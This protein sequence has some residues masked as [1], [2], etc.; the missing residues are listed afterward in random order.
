MR[1]DWAERFWAKVRKD[2]PVLRPELGPCWVWTAAKD[3]GYGVFRV[4]G[5]AGRT[6]R[7]THCAWEL[8]EGRVVARGMQICH[9]CDNPSCVRPSHLFE[10]TVLDNARDRESKGR[11]NQ[12]RG[13]DHGHATMTEALV[14][15]IVKLRRAGVTQKQVAR[16]VGVRRCAVADIDA[17]RRWRHVT[18]VA[19]AK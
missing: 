9:R 4:G 15:R 12:P 11:G 5:R 2:G 10:G 3:E 14:R 8:G 6:V 16:I 7:A 1:P 17:G 19:R 13:E 18:H